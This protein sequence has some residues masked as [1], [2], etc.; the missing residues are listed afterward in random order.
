MT[1]PGVQSVHFASGRKETIMTTFDPTVYKETT[2]EQWQV[3]AEPWHRWGPVIGA[4]LGP[5]TEIMLDLA[6]VLAG[7]C[8]LDVAAG[9]GEQT[10]TAARRIGPNGYVLATDSAPRGAVVTER[11]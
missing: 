5:A 4:W 9:A 6:D 1:V 2:H 11:G 7:S 8:V 3:A 10:L